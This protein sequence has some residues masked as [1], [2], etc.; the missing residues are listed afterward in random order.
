MSKYAYVV[1]LYGSSAY[2]AG[3]M[4]L[5]YSLMKTGT[6]YDKIIMVTPDV[7]QEH[8]DCLS[9][10]YDRVIEIP[11]IDANPGY[12][13]PDTRFTKIF[14]KLTPISLDE[15]EKVAIVDLDMVVVQN[16]DVIFDL[17]A[18][19]A[20]LRHKVY[21]R[22]NMVAYAHGER[23][24]ADYHCK[25]FIGGINAGLMVLSTSKKEWA[26]IK[27]DIMRKPSKPVRDPEQWYIYRRYC[28]DWTNLSFKYNYQFGF[29]DLIK[30][31][32]VT[33]EDVAVLHYSGWLKPWAYFIEGRRGKYTNI[34]Y[35]TFKR[36][37]DLWY[38][39]Y[40][41]CCSYVESKGCLLKTEMEVY[42][43]KSNQPETNIKGSTS[44]NQ[45]VRDS[46]KTKE[47][48]KD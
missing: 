5:G 9:V 17:P 46:E 11:Y 41:A 28:K 4:V 43:G 14:T 16:I 38:D 44:F 26:S 7:K 34:Y 3:A 27:K 6:V 37:F 19:A 23:I 24:D 35:E 18:P 15:Y 39:V 29:G 2:L 47:D 10:I 25:K 30:V 45:F 13:E 12:F 22:R 31:Y 32:N 36:F 42:E 33:E 40:V 1:I 48:P 8:R 21:D 20:R